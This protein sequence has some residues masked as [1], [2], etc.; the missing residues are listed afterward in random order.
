M[1]NSDPVWDVP[2]AMV[3]GE[4]PLIYLALARSVPPTSG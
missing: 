2:E 1:R 4:G 3:D